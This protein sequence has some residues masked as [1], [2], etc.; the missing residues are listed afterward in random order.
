MKLKKNN[1]VNAMFQMSSLT[2]IIFLLLIFFM[3][4]STLVAPNAIQV[5]LPSATGKTI[6]SQ[7]VFVTVSSNNEYFINN[8]KIL[9]NDLEQSIVNA[10]SA[11]KESSPTIVLRADKLSTHEAVVDVLKLGP[12]YDFKVILATSPK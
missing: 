11:T 10:M 12:K 5:N 8:K 1:K 2:D 3:L 9:K 4:T 6:T 7:S